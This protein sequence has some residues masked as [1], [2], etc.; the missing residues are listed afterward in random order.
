M[1]RGKRYTTRPIHIEGDIAYV[2]LTKG[3][4]AIIDATDAPLVENVNWHALTGSRKQKRNQI[5][6][7]RSA[8]VDG[9]SRCILLHRIIMGDPEGLSVDH[10]DGDGL[11]CRRAN[12]RV[13]THQ[14]N[15]QNSPRSRRNTA[16]VKGATL[17]GDKFEAT[18]Q[19]GGIT[20][21]LG[22]YDTKAEA[23]AAYQGVA[24]VLFG[25]FAR[26]A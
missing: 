21:Y 13:C 24:S 8:I 3:Y 9:R 17:R 22:K 2:T 4:V 18:I 5:Y 7:A 12:L 20:Y 1:K 10:V 14:Q 26:A 23:S 6:A 19:T 15:L 16:G 25:R 11:N